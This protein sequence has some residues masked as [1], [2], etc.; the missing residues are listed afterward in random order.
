MVEVVTKIKEE[1]K[2]SLRNEDPPER[3]N[4]PIDDEE[5]IVVPLISSNQLKLLKKPSAG[6]LN[7]FDF[8]KFLYIFILILFYSSRCAKQAGNNAMWKACAYCRR[9]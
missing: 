4:T 9:R 6:T 8:M 1:N 3:P 5:E 2:D 7:N